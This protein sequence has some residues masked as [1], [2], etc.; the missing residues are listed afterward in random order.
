M[1]GIY[2]SDNIIEEY[3]SKLF[4]LPDEKINLNESFIPK[5]SF[6][7]FFLHLLILMVHRKNL[8]I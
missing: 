2:I 8:P 6:S 3:S 5:A 4:N 1:L 7:F